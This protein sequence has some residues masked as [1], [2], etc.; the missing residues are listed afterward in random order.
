MI[1]LFLPSEE[2]TSRQIIIRGK[3][4]RYLSSVLRVKPG[5]LITIFD[6]QGNRHICN[7]SEVHKKEVLVE[8]IKKEI[9]TAESPISIMLAQGLPK[10]D[11]MDFIIQK[12][13]ELGVKKIIPLVT[14]RSHVRYT[15]KG[16][17]WRKIAVSASQQSGREKVPDVDEPVNFKEFLNPPSPPFSPSI[18]PLSKGGIEGGLKGIIFFEEEKN[19]NLKKVLKDFVETTR[20]RKGI[21]TIT[22]LIGPEGGFSSTEAEMAIKKGF[23]AASLGPRILRTETA[24]LAAISI[25]QYELGDIG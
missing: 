14:E 5:E 15:A 9:Y 1:R 20:Y 24:A 16:K 4:A 19:Q 3:D 18:S 21:M 8:K 11:K 23:I 12:S 17:R 10:G 2:L 22:L 25:I 13:T 6:G 7:I